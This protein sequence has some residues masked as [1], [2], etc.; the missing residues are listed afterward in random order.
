MVCSATGGN[1]LDGDIENWILVKS[2]SG[3][4]SDIRDVA[5]MPNDNK[6][7]ASCSIDSTI[8]VWRYMDGAWAECA[9]LSAH[10]DYVKGIAFD[11]IRKY[12][13]SQSD[14]NTI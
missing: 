6:C 2:L 9:K 13:V 1:T 12:L 11:P 7:L 5:W 4:N 8:I 10:S 14:D 3:H